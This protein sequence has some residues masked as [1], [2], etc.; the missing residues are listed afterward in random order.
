MWYKVLWNKKLS[1]IINN[2]SFISLPSI[3]KL[4]PA[5]TM[6]GHF[7]SKYNVLSSATDTREFLNFRLFAN[8]HNDGVEWRTINNQIWWRQQDHV[9]LNQK[10][11]QERI[12]CKL[13]TKNVYFA[14][15]EIN[16]FSGENEILDN[17]N[18][19]P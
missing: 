3:Y 13:E 2:L 14:R 11:F 19:R 10:C 1:L 5:T 15:F 4:F 6:C 8:K 9:N 7:N 17:I 18:L 12:S 16:L